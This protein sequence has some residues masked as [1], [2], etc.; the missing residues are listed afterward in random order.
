MLVV[1]TVAAFDVDG[2]LTSRDC[3]VPFLRRVA[4]SSGLVAGLGRRAP[5]LIPA[6]VRRDRDALKTLATAAVFT[7]RT[8]H[9][10][11]AVGRQFADHV[12]TSWL[13]ADVVAGLDEHR[14]KG[15]HV[16]LVSASYAVYLVPLAARLGGAD[17]IGTL[18]E[19]D[20]DGTCTGVLDGGNCR[21]AAK[22][23]RLHRWLDER[24]GGRD[25][26]TLWAY[27]DSAGDE[28]MLADADHPVWVGRKRTVS[29][30]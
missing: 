7:G 5:Q 16:V 4:G 24:F 2:T 13:R 9:E 21:G 14:R 27:G 30:R 22:V 29:V 15:D 18:L 23:V 10:I 25:N 11:D 28:P 19:V 3:V 20:G 26:V 1:P 12:A 8:I 6:L 17:V